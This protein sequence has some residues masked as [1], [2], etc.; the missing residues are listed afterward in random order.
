MIATLEIIFENLVISFCFLK[1]IG[2]N[3]LIKSKASSELLIRSLKDNV[4]SARISKEKWPENATSTTASSSTT[5]TS[6]SIASTIASTTS[7]IANASSTSANTMDVKA[8]NEKQKKAE[9]EQSSSN[10]QNKIIN[11]PE[12][13]VNLDINDE[14]TEEAL[15]RLRLV[16][17]FKRLSKADLQY[18]DVICSSFMCL[19]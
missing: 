4:E 2:K 14:I 11:S 3:R 8:T 17:H 10:S 9:E 12:T 18:D 6:A 7:P 19:L 13:I 15:R 5:S 16:K 1:K